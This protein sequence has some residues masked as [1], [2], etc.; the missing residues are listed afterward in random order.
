MTWKIAKAQ[1]QY[2][3]TFDNADDCAS[4]GVTVDKETALTMDDK[5]WTFVATYT[6]T[7]MN[8]ADTKTYSD[9]LNDGMKSVTAYA[10]VSY[11]N[12]D[13]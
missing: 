3:A 1:D 2:E 10:L 8:A 6:N 4:K 12:G 9:D 11:M 7:G 5:S 13:N